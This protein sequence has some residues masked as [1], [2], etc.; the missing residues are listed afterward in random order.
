MILYVLRVAVRTILTFSHSWLFRRVEPAAWGDRGEGRGPGQATDQHY[1]YHLAHQ[2]QEQ[3]EQ[4]HQGIH[5]GSTVTSL[6]GQ[7]TCSDVIGRSSYTYWRH[8]SV[9]IHMVMSLVDQHTLHIET[10][11][12]ECRSPKILFLQWCGSGLIVSGSRSTKFDQS[13]SRSIKSPNFYNI[14]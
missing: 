13:G 5:G 7:H 3:E 12:V 2:R 11:N 8:W 6:V 14:F 4:R 9:N 10:F 1:L